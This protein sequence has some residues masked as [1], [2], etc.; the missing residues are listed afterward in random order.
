MEAENN[1]PCFMFTLYMLAVKLITS[2]KRIASF[3]YH[4][5]ICNAMSYVVSV[6]TYS[7]QIL[8]MYNLH[9]PWTRVWFSL[10]VSKWRT[11][12]EF[13]FLYSFSDWIKFYGE[14]SEVMRAV[15]FHIRQ[16]FFFFNVMATSLETKVNNMC[17]EYNSKNKIFVYKN[18]L[19]KTHFLCV[20]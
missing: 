7:L 19:Q 3:V 11:I 13:K 8:N 6:I 1:L 10:T 5:I 4:W 14:T 20:L 15:A 18:N 16:L 17:C 2:W 9:E 12:L